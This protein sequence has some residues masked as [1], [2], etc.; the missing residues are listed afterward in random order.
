MSAL[1]EERAWFSGDQGHLVRI[2][3]VPIKPYVPYLYRLYDRDDRLLYIGVSESLAGRL[4]GHRS[5]YGQ[6]IARV[7]LEQYPTRTL[8]EDA[9]RQAITAESP[10]D[11]LIAGHGRFPR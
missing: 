10:R 1:Y 2:G 4:R 7:E 6:E 8:A 5:R 3:P 9:K 11:N